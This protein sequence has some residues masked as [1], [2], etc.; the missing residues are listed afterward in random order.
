MSF[1]VTDRI[2]GEGQEGAKRTRITCEDISKK[3]AHSMS[4]AQRNI[5]GICKQM[6]IYP[7]I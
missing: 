2:E 6:M 1:D 3:H 7:G 4:S 5:P